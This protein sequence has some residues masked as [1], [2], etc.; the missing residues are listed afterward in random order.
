MHWVGWWSIDLK[1]YRCIQ[2]MHSSPSLPVVHQ[3]QSQYFYNIRLAFAL[4]PIICLE[5]P[6]F[7]SSMRHKTSSRTFIFKVIF[8][9]SQKRWTGDISLFLSFLPMSP[10]MA[11]GQHTTLFA[12]WK[13]HVKKRQDQV[14][15]R[16]LMESH[17]RR[18]LC[19]NVSCIWN[20]P[21][22]SNTTE[23]PWLAQWIHTLVDVFE[24]FFKRKYN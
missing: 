21:Q 20:T 12:V 14:L 5:L 8:R 6:S 4:H 22:V 7:W 10:L 19:S 15:F 24:I 17:K 9:I 18:S 11:W 2:R 13:I 23:L 16:A 3:R 1:S